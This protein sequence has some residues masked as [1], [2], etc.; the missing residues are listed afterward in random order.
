MFIQTETTANTARM[1]F[2]PGRAVLSSG[3]VDFRDVKSSAR[4]PLAQRLFAIEGVTGV[5]LDPG[6]GG[7]YLCAHEHVDLHS[8]SEP[9]S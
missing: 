7:H 8:V 1:T 2:L 3:T 6:A 5:Y 9:P 4:S